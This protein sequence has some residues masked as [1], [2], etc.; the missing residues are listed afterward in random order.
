MRM[1]WQKNESILRH[2]LGSLDLDTVYMNG[3]ELVATDVFFL[4]LIPVPPSRFRPVSNIRADK[5]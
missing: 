1:V 4:D 5:R 2:V 3:G